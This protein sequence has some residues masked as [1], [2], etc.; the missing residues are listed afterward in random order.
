M[1]DDESGAILFFDPTDPF[2]PVGE[3]PVTLQDSLGLVVSP[4]GSRLRRMPSA[5]THV[6]ER[7]SVATLSRDGMFRASLQTSAS[8]QLATQ[9]R[10]LY[11]S[12]PGDGYLRR[13]EAS[14]RSRLPGAVMTPGPINDDLE[15]NRF[16][17]SA[18]LQARLFAAPSQGGLVFLPAV[19]SLSDVLPILRPGP[20]QTAVVLAPR[21]E[22]DRFEVTLPVGLRV[23]ELPM[24]QSVET[25]FGRFDV[26][27]TTEGSRLV[28]VLSLRVNRNVVS[29]D[30]YAEL[31]AFVDRFRDIERQPAVLARQP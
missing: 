7:R 11:R 16:E 27:W 12:L 23:D 26:R 21:D 5:D 9:E 6:R 30:R 22:Q 28:R 3:L 8:G 18:Q 2:T 25:P 4:T 29:P 10:R 20:R 19:V 24:P 17:H 31:R 13:L 14:V 1:T 15:H